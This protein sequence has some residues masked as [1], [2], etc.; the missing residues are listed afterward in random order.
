MKKIL[1]CIFVSTLLSLMMAFIVFAEDRGWVYNDDIWTYI[2]NTGTQVTDTWKMSG[3]N[4]YYLN[5]EG[6]LAI[7]TIV[8]SNNKYYYVD[9]HGVMIKNSWVCKASDEDDNTDAPYR[10]YYFG[11]TGAA[12]TGTDNS[13]NLKTINNKK[14]AFDSEGRM[15]FGFVDESGTIKTNENAITDSIYYFGTYDDGALYTGWLNYTE[16]LDG[17]DKDSVWFYYKSNGKMIK[18]DTK[19]INGKKYTFDD[20]GVMTASWTSMDASSSSQYYSTDSDG[21]LK[22]KSWVYAIPS[23]DINSED[24]DSETYRWFYVDN[25]GKTIVNKTKLI[26]NK[27]YVFDETGIMKTEFVELDGDKVSNSKY[28][29]AYKASDISADEIYNKFDNHSNIFAYFSDSED[30]GYMRT[31]NVKIELYDDTYTFSFDKHGLPHNGIYQNK[32]YRCGILQTSDEKNSVK[33]YY[34]GTDYK[35]YVVSSTGVILKSGRTGKNDSDECYAIYGEVGDIDSI[36]LFSGDD[37][38]K[39]ASY[40]AKHG[41]M[42][43]FDSKYDWKEISVK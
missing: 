40:F 15:L 28:V 12:Y 4:W 36:H 3:G 5:D 13:V 41:D 29:N 10:W 37:A 34:D 32:L 33:K 42:T 2:D 24:H 7:D 8:E 30:S 6:K 22:K 25:T 27:Y 11:S 18:D 26:N 16:A 17:Y 39:A 35:Y 31:G 20:K 19:T 43:G 9:E 38:S 21:A 1:R 14:Y 23:S